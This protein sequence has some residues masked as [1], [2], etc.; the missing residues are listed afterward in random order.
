MVISVIR[1]AGLKLMVTLLLQRI[2][3][4]GVC[5]STT[6]FRMRGHVATSSSDARA[7]T[8]VMGTTFSSGTFPINSGR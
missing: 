3:S 8:Q 6:R 2:R 4:I 7:L 5:V 1:M